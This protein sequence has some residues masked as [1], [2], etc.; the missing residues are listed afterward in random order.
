MSVNFKMHSYVVLYDMIVQGNEQETVK[1]DNYFKTGYE[2]I[3][4]GYKECQLEGDKM[5]WNPLVSGGQT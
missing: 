5:Q 3:G 1:V 2:E 4:D